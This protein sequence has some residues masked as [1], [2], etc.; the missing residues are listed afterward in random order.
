LTKEVS[1][2]DE[3]GRYLH[4]TEIEIRGW[5]RGM[6]AAGVLIG[7]CVIMGVAVAAA[8]VG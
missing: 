5:L 3:K 8:Y 2:Y 1:V 6:L 4:E 7:V